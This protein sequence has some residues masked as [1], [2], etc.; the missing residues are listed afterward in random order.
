[1]SEINDGGPAFPCM[2]P[3]QDI[4]VGQA[5]GYPDPESGMTL[6]DYFAAAA[7]QG[8]LANSRLSER[9]PIINVDDAW[10]YASSMLEERI[11]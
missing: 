2:P 10:N 1:M 7:L 4:G 6:R 9:A 3:K 5:S 11:A 8:I